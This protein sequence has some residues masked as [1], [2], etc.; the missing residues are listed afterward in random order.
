METNWKSQLLII[1]PINRTVAINGTERHSSIDI[2]V[3]TIGGQRFT[4]GSHSNAFLHCLKESI[5]SVLCMYSICLVCIEDMN[6]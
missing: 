1:E 2:I 5:F 6:W 4:P 3:L